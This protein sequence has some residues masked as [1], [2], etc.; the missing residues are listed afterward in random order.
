M[1]RFG[2][3]DAA[4]AKIGG[5]DSGAGEK[6]DDDIGSLFAEDE[7]RAFDAGDIRVTDDIDCEFAVQA[8]GFNQKGA[9]IVVRLRRCC[10]PGRVRVR[11]GRWG[12]EA[13]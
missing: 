10:F 13:L 5:L 12:R 11:S 2:S 4:A 1:E 3:T 8:S 9:N 6:I 7:I